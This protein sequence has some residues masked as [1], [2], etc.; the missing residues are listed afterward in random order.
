MKIEVIHRGGRHEFMEKKYADILVKL[1]RVKIAD[2]VAPLVVDDEA[3]DEAPK[4][5]YTRKP[6][7]DDV[8]SSEDPTESDE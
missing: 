3:G 6:K 8:S 4:R 5:K 7:S 1:G 2:P